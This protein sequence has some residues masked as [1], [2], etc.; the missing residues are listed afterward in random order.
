MDASAVHVQH[1]LAHVGWEGLAD[2][3]PHLV[4]VSLAFLEQVVIVKADGTDA[5]AFDL[6][7][8]RLIFAIVYDTVCVTED[9]VLLVA[10]WYLLVLGIRCSTRWALI[11]RGCSPTVGANVTVAF[12]RTSE[13]ASIFQPALPFS[14]DGM[15]FGKYVKAL[16]TKLLV[17]AFVA[18]DGVP[19]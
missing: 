10:D 8:E 16:K 19:R 14:V 17:G 9:M 7:Q 3:L 11:W 4:C 12:P 6:N 1:G 13:H 15:T 18:L 2:A 5:D